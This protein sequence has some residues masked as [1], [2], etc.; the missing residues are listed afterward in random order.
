MSRTKVIG[1]ENTLKCIR[2]SLRQQKLPFPSHQR[3]ISTH[4]VRFIPITYQKK[5]RRIS[6]SVSHYTFTTSC[7]LQ[8]PSASAPE[9]RPTIPWPKSPNP[10]PYEIFNL[11]HSATEKEIKS[12]YFLLVKQYHPDHAPQTSVDRFRKV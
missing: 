3:S 6:L 8:E 4:N 9:P 10:S 2:Y 11:P 1:L 12:R 5:R 7:I